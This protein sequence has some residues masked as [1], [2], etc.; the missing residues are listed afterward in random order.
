VAVIAAGVPGVTSVLIGRRKVGREFDRA[1]K[2]GYGVRNVA[3]VKK[4]EAPQP[5]GDTQR[6]TV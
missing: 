1:I 6:L 4:G 2:V 3:A 5:V